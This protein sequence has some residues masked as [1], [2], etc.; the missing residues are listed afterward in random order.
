MRM[1]QRRTGGNARGQSGMRRAEDR[2]WNSDLAA[3]ADLNSSS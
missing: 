1:A 2:I 3:L